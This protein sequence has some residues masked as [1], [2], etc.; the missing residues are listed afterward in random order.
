VTEFLAIFLGTAAIVAAVFVVLGFVLPGATRRI[1]KTM[2]EA[3]DDPAPGRHSYCPKCRRTRTLE[4]VGGIRYA[5]TKSRRKRTLG[6]CTS[7][8]ALRIVRIVHESRMTPEHRAS[9][10]LT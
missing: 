2:R 5:A 3:G 7:C 9:V 10:E 4:D 8:K 6:Y 1:Q